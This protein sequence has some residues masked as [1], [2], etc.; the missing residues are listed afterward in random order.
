MKLSLVRLVSLPNLA[1]AAL[2]VLIA[3]GAYVNH[4]TLAGFN[5]TA[6]NATSTISTATL[7]LTATPDGGA[8]GGSLN[9]AVSDFI[10]GDYIQ[11]G[12]EVINIGNIP[13]NLTLTVSDANPGGSASNATLK[14]T[15]ANNSL[16]LTVEKCTDNTYTTCGAGTGYAVIGG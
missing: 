2:G 15:D 12:V 1:L 4:G 11:K 5:A 6:S 3:S 10:P 8:N 13:A 7:D 14:G 9:V 16:H